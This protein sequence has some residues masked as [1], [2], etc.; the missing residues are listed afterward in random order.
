[1]GNLL[2]AYT[3]QTRIVGEIP[4]SQTP[5]FTTAAPV[6]DVSQLEG[7]SLVELL[8]L[9]LLEMRIM[10]QQLY[11]LPGLLSSGL[12]AQDEPQSMRVEQSIFN[13]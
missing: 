3:E 7:Q 5:E 11:E 12:P 13:I 1:M 2:M 6:V 9:I 8:A 4:T 10:N